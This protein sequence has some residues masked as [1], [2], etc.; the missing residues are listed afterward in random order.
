MYNRKNASDETALEI[1][2]CGACDCT[3]SPCTCLKN[4]CCCQATNR[5]TDANWTEVQ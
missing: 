4:G 2:C 5:H 1:T 3:T